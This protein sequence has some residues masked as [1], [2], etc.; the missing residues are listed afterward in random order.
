MSIQHRVRRRGRRLI[1]LSLVLALGALTTGCDTA[2]DAIEEDPA[3][4]LQEAIDALEDWDGLRAEF[5][6]EA[7]E[8]VRAELAAEED[9]SDEE[10]E[11]L[12]GSSVSVRAG[13]DDDA[14]TAG[15]ETTLVVD[16]TSVFDLR[17]LDEQYFVR[18]DFDALS[19]LSED[20]DLGDVEDLLVTARVLGLGDV[21]QAIADG[22]WIE[23]I[24]VDDLME[25]TDAEPSE[26]PEVDEQEAQALTE[27]LSTT[28]QTFVSED[29]D[30]TYIG[31]EDVGEHVRVVTDGAS[32]DEL[33]TELT[34]ELGRT[35]V[36]R[37]VADDDL[38][39]LD[40]DDDTTV[41]IDAWIDE[42]EI[43]QLGLDL[44]TLDDADELPD[45]M[46]VL[47][48]VEEFAG[49]IEAPEDP[50]PF[51]LL[52][53][54]GAF[55]GGPGGDPFGDE[56]FGQ[57]DPF[58]EGPAGDDAADEDIPFDDEDLDTEC[59]PA[60]DLAELEEAA[61]PEAAEEIEGLIDAG[62]LELC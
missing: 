40:V 34:S 2:T 24:G 11:L 30:V 8:A 25:L 7:D 13:G 18:L 61:G 57:D 43:R 4:A 32:L 21:A 5:R 53:L 35:G 9:L 22:R 27:R 47:M 23:L 31:S 48:A 10:I 56:P 17:I 12:L 38:D 44:G 1:G 15:F 62:I 28:F 42:G 60:E 50:E 46:L 33:F 6:L 39:Q 52:R 26:E 55:F 58:D 19:D 20:A 37:D 41:S 29:A 51:D 49:S 59:I 54:V 14:E 3:G 45:D 16:E 36:L